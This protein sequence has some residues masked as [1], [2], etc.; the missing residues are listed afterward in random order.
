LCAF[1]TQFVDDV[2]VGEDEIRVVVARRSEEDF[3]PRKKL[4]GG[5]GDER[6]AFRGVGR[7]GRTVSDAT[8]RNA[9]SPTKRREM[10][11]DAPPR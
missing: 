9:V 3:C 1:V 2:V 4:L 6:V 5:S 8:Y 11:A 7:H 10:L